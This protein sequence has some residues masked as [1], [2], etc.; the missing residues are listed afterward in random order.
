[1]YIWL[2]YTSIV[3]LIGSI[4]KAQ[5]LPPLNIN[6]MAPVTMQYILNDSLYRLDSLQVTQEKEKSLM[7]QCSTGLFKKILGVYLLCSREVKGTRCLTTNF[8]QKRYLYPFHVLPLKTCYPWSLEASPNILNN[9]LS[10]K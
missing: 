6:S 1:M 9:V 7:A 8:V 2:V 5:E 10:I 4:V 3:P